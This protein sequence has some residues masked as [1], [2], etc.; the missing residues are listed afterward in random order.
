MAFRKT[1]PSGITQAVDAYIRPAAVIRDS[2][3]KSITVAWGAWASKAAFEAGEPHLQLG[4]PDTISQTDDPVGYA[5]ALSEP[6]DMRRAYRMAAAARAE[7]SAHPLKALLDGAQNVL[8]E[9][10]T[11]AEPIERKKQQQQVAP[12]PRR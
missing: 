6:D 5:A 2:V 8:E 12:A 7:N 4:A 3:N 1:V 11:P 10:Q 9:G